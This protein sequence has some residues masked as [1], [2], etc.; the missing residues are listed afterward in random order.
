MPPPLTEIGCG[1]KGWLSTPQGVPL[2][3]ASTMETVDRT[4]AT[5][6]NPTDTHHEPAR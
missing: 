2:P 4:T 5:N 1:A 3:L 6:T